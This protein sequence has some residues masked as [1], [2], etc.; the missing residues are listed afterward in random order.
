MQALA[1]MCS[2]VPGK[3]EQ[4]ARYYGYYSNVSR[5]KR[6]KAQIDDQIPYILEPEMTDKAFRKNWAR[7][8]QTI[9]EVDP[10]V[11]SR[12]QGSMRVIAFIENEDVIKKIL[13]HLGIW[14]IKR[15]PSP[16]ANAP[17]IISDSDYIP[18]VD[19]YVIDSVY[20]VESYLQ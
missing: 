20:P 11:C 14:D 18:S 4:M 17:P 2:H 12:C 6:K 7:L 8:I 9:Y 10:L 5:G 15:K 3:G 13:K 16:V 19:D 1:A